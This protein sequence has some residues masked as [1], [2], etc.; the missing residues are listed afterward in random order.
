MSDLQQIG[1]IATTV[2]GEPFA[3]ADA[4]SSMADDI[5]GVTNVFSDEITAQPAEQQSKNHDT[6]SVLR[7]AQTFGQVNDQ[8]RV[9]ARGAQQVSA[10][11]KTLST[12]NPGGRGASVR[13]TSALAAG[14]LRAVHVTRAGDTPQRL[15]IRF[16]RTPDHAVDILFANK[17]PWTTVTFDVGTTLI[18]PAAP[19]KKTKKPRA[20]P[21]TSSNRRTTSS[22]RRS[23]SPCASRSSPRPSPRATPR[24]PS[25]SHPSR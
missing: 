19:K 12:R 11:V 14:G 2:E 7:A 22:G 21:R 18:I 16:Y 5:V 10:K 13:Q 1:Q 6:I 25:R 23:C 15:S 8:A 24:A 17:L 9:M 3:I 20:G 4:A